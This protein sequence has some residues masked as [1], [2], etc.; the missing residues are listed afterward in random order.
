V[1]QLKLP[2]ENPGR[3]RKFFWPPVTGGVIKLTSAQMTLLLGGMDW[4]RLEE[5]PIKKPEM[6]G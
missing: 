3:F 2:P 4:R 5:N 6:A 1:T